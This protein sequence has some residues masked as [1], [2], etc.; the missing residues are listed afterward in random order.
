VF[1]HPRLDIGCVTIN[2]GI[3]RNLTGWDRPGFTRFFATRNGPRVLLHR[4]VQLPI[5]SLAE[6]AVSIIAK[7]VPFE[8]GRVTALMAQS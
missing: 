5:I 7:L 3:R 8:T 6:V 4:P 1:L 2:Q